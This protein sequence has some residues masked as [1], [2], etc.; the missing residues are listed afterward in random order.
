MIPQIL[1]PKVPDWFK[2]E[3][4][5]IDKNLTCLFNCR[6]ERFKIYRRTKIG[7]DCI[8]TIENDDGT[9]RPIDR[10]PLAKLRE[11]DIVARWGSLAAYEK[12]LDDKLAEWKKQQNI[13]DDHEIKCDLKND[14]HLWKE[15]AENFRS[16]RINDRPT[17]KME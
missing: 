13:K 1:S 3:L 10:R 16:G 17:R 11:M 15:A 8:L 14:R 12:Y 9:F 4:Y 7:W 2:D 5:I 6:L